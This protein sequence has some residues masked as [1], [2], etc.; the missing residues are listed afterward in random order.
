MESSDGKLKQLWSLVHNYKGKAKA[1]EP[2]AGDR[3]GSKSRSLN[4]IKKDIRRM[5]AKHPHFHNLYSDQNLAKNPRVAALMQEFESD[6]LKLVE[7]VLLDKLGHV[8]QSTYKKMQKRLAA[9]TNSG[10]GDTGL[11]LNMIDQQL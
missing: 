2:D 11:S 4:D 7:I 6:L 9:L 10:M 1:P 8:D 3:L 5:L